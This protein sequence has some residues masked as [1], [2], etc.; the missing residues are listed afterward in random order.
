V[1]WQLGNI[2]SS[3]C[4][5]VPS[6]TKC[7]RRMLFDSH[8]VKSKISLCWM[9]KLHNLCWR[10]KWLDQKCSFLLNSLHKSM[11]IHFFILFHLVALRATGGWYKN[12]VALFSD[13]KFNEDFKNAVGFLMWH[14]LG[15]FLGFKDIMHFLWIACYIDLR[16]QG[17]VQVVVGQEASGPA[18]E[19]GA[20]W[21]IIGG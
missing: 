4:I 5:Q 1:A 6:T 18:W 3:T 17:Q 9:S 10:W 16:W 15:A 11:H 14:T 21:Q 8:C 13:A 20:R 7:C 19:V 2:V 12:Q